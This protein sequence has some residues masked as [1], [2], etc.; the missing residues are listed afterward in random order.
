M[1]DELRDWREDLD[2][3]DLPEIY[4]DI[5]SFIGLPAALE[6]GEKMGGEHFYLPKID[7]FLTRQRNR[8][9]K[10]DL[11]AGHTYKQVARRY[12]ITERWVREIE[13]TMKDERQMEMF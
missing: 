13:Q 5:A 2:T 10:A 6:L 9:I 11:A 12:R 3:D 1:T 7:S 4:R 8:L